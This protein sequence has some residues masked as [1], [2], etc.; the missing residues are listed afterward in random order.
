M[1][2]Q[3][4]FLLGPTRSI[5]GTKAPASGLPDLARV[6]GWIWSN[7]R[8]PVELWRSPEEQREDIAR[9]LGV[10]RLPSGEG[11]SNTK[12]RARTPTK[13][14][15]TCNRGI[16]DIVAISGKSIHRPYNPKQQPCVIEFMLGLMLVAIL[17]NRP[18]PRLTTSHSHLT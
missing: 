5:L 7:S 11:T 8:S 14:K 16:P 12:Q 1:S 18:Q 6:I 17:V 10:C 13:S 4:S 15:T 2:R 3:A 9:D